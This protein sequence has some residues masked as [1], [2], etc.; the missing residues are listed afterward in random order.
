[1]SHDGN[2]DRDTRRT[3][4]AITV[5][6]LAET[7]GFHACCERWSWLAPRTI[8]SLIRSGRKQMERRGR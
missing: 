7:H 3:P 8:S 2:W 1:M 4:A 5:A 6:R